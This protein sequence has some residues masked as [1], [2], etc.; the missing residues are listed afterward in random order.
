MVWWHFLFRE[1]NYGSVSIILIA[2]RIHSQP[3][4]L[5]MYGLSSIRLMNTATFHIF[6]RLFLKTCFKPVVC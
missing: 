5:C 4:D 2:A 6:W 1:L 3:F